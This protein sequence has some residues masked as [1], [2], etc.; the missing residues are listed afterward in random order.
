MIRLPSWKLQQI[1]TVKYAI[2]RICSIILCSIRVAPS[3][4]FFE[5]VSLNRK[6][7]KVFWVHVA[8][9][10]VSNPG[11]YPFTG[12]ISWKLS[13]ENM[14]NTI[15]HVVFEHQQLT[16]VELLTVSW[17]KDPKS[18]TFKKHRILHIKIKTLFLGLFSWS[19][20]LN[21]HSCMESDKESA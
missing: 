17:K 6:L 12:T 14:K 18:T 4:K 2:S 7:L 11:S 13:F 21:L 3:L 1:K 5:D 16:S 10:V 15:K 19:S 8:Y 20:G 9:F